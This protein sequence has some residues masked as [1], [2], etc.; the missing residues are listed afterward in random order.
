MR[1]SYRYCTL[2]RTL[3]TS[4]ETHPHSAR[5]RTLAEWWLVDSARARTLAEWWLVNSARARTLAE[6]VLERAATP[7][8][9]VDGEVRDQAGRMRVARLV[10]HT[11]ATVLRMMSSSTSQTS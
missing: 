6:S 3:S 2:D 7:R 4:H 8:G 11:S 1:E 9:A 5:V 10:V